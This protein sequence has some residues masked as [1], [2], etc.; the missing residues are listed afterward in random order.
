MKKSVQGI[1]FRLLFTK[2]QQQI[3]SDA[4]WQGEAIRISA[5]SDTRSNEY[6]DRV[7]RNE[8]REY[9]KLRNFIDRITK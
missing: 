7:L 1:M 9:Q 4:L 6:R 3:L 8:M 2:E 5:L